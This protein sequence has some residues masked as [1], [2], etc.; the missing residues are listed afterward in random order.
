MATICRVIEGIARGD[1]STALVLTMHYLQHAHAAR[2]R[3]WYPEVYK[4]LC[5]ESI[6]GIALLN[7]ARV[8]PELGTPARGGLPATIAIRTTEGWRLT[9]HTPRAVPSSAILLFG[10]GQLKMNHKLG[11]F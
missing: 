8:E 5:R 10:H 1:A 6:E 2:S 7:A 3:R 4:R 9:G 11:I